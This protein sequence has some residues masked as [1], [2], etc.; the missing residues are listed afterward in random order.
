MK[1]LIALLLAAIMVL[2]LAACASSPAADQPANDQTTADTTTEET[3]TEEKTE[4]KTEDTAASGDVEVVTYYCSIGAYL[5][6]LQAEVAN[7]NETTGKEKGVEIQIISDINDYSNNARALMQGGTFYDLV[8]AGTGSADWIVSGWIQDLNTIDNAE[9][10]ELIAGYE[11][12]IQNGINIQQGILVALPLEVVPIKFAVN[13]DL[14]EKNGLELP[15]TWEDV[16]NCAK[17]ITENGNGEE[18]GYG[19][20]T[21]TAGMIRRG[22]FKVAMNSTGRGWFDPN[23]ATYDFS[24]FK[25]IL[26]IEAKM[27]QEGLLLGADDLGID[28]IRAQFAAGKV[29]MFYAPSYDY[30]VYTSQ[31]PAECNWTVIDPPAI[32]DE[33]PYKGVY[34]DRVGCSITAPAYEA[35]SD[36]HKQAIIDAFIFLNS[37]ELNSKIYSVGGMIPYKTEVIE[38]TE[39]SADLGPQWA[40]FGD[41]S[42]YASMSLYPDSLLPL[43]GENFNTVLDSYLRG[44]LDDLDAICADLA[45][46]YNAAYKE[47]K[48]SGDVDLSQYEYAY[49]ISK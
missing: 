37:D 15:K 33:T 41:I 46:R 48:E 43:E 8:D 18:F 35:A 49:D 17:V 27:M 5:S 16:Y 6:T 3:K 45:E 42:N 29:G 30:G 31:F 22:T 19:W 21:W 32:V 20:C 26:E 38:N 11:P 4:E 44:D 9:L 24:Q 7:W 25:P 1:K 39:L 34:L 23:T 10:K 2:S 36:A 12:Y 47:L 40:Q 13:L 28:E 14:F